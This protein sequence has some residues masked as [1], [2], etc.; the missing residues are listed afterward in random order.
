MD[1]PRPMRPRPTGF[2]GAELR[3]GRGRGVRVILRSHRALVRFIRLSEVKIRSTTLCRGPDSQT[4]GAMG[5]AC[6]P[7]TPSRQTRPTSPAVLYRR[8]N[9]AGILI[10]PLLPRGVR[11]TSFQPGRRDLLRD[12]RIARRFKGRWTHLW[13][14][15]MFSWRVIL[16]FAGSWGIWAKET[17]GV[18]GL[19]ELLRVRKAAS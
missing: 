17:F 6:S 9:V 7:I 4:D 8:I 1:Q 19:V 11:L 13:F 10:G 3:L 12:M 5:C 18:K 15:F 14:G 16:L 2:S